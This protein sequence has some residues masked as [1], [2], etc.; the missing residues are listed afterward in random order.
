MIPKETWKAPVL[1]AKHPLNPAAEM[2]RD[3]VRPILTIV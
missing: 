1:Q 2:Q 3:Q